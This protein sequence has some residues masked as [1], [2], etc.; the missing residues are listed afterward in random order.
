M[1]D[2]EEIKIEVETYYNKYD[3]PNA[4]ATGDIT[5]SYVH[6][7]D[8]DTTLHTGIKVIKNNYNKSNLSKEVNIPKRIRTVCENC[9]S[10]LEITENDTHIG[11]LGFKYITCPCCGEETSVE[12][13]ECTDITKSNVKFPTHFL[14]V[15]KGLRNVKEEKEDRINEYIQ[16]GI[17]YLR[18]NKKETYWT[19]QTRD[20]FLIVFRYEGDEEYFV[21]VTKDYYETEVSFEPEDF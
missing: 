19:A 13:L 2:K 4:Q 21:I 5:Y 16:E 10:E 11:W 1:K 15:T 9:E 7:N 20:M 12:E 17:S 14:R 8:N 6:R 3:I 18:K